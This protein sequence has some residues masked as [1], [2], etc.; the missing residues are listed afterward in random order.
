MAL[1][2]P[3]TF[4]NLTTAI[5]SYLDENFTYIKNMFGAPNGFATL[6][7]SGNIAQV[8]TTSAACTGNAATATKLAATKNINGT[9][10]D[11]SASIDVTAFQTQ[12]GDLEKT[13]GVLYQNTTSRARMVS[14]TASPGVSGIIN[15]NVG[16]TSS[17]SIILSNSVTA[18]WDGSVT[19]IVLPNYY[20]QVDM[21]AGTLKHWVEWS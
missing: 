5:L 21:T 8:V 2:F 20:Y 15:V 11:G 14:V 17:P 7:G 16:P 6:D 9:A 1:S 19:F 4:A 12:S 18:N 13:T 3:R 10:F